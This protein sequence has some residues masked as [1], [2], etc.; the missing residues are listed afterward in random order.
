M[1]TPMGLRRSAT[2]WLLVSAASLALPAGAQGG[3]PGEPGVVEGVC[4]T[5]DAAL[6]ALPEAGCPAGADAGLEE[7]RNFGVVYP[8]RLTRSA[9]PDKSFLKY[10]KRTRGLAVI[11][12][13]RN[14]GYHDEGRRMERERRWAEELG[15]RYVPFMVNGFDTSEHARFLR[16]LMEETP[17]GSILIHCTGGKDRTGNIVAILRLQDGLSYAEAVLEM[18]AYRHEPDKDVELHRH[19]RAKFQEARRPVDG[20]RPE[21]ASRLSNPNRCRAKPAGSWRLPLFR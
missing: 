18:K 13:L 21:L 9:A 15:V 7:D 11:V 4:V 1:K 2:H 12:D 8:G 10:L 20:V 17:G 19:L 6:P 5:C 16:R 14:P 3:I